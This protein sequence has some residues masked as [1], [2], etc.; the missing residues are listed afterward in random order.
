MSRE[1]FEPLTDATLDREIDAALGIDPSSDFLARVRTRVA[2]ERPAGSPRGALWIATAAL[3][4]IVIAVVAGTSMMWRNGPPRLESSRI[5]TQRTPAPVV[6]ARRVLAEPKPR[7][8]SHEPRAGLK[9]RLQTRASGRRVAMWN[10]GTSSSRQPE[11]LVAKDESAGFRRLLAA[12]SQGRV[13]R[14]PPSDVESD[15]ETGTIRPQ[16]LSIAPVQIALMEAAAV[17]QGEIR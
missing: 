4:A 5:H 1:R 14:V 2:S 16:P 7:L 9:P 17:E 10:D 8:D 12:A 15:A 3:A 11:V 13:S 6:V